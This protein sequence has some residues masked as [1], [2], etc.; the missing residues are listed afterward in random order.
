M[1]LH[2]LLHDMMPPQWLLNY[3]EQELPAEE[4]D[5]HDSLIE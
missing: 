3:E 5:L 2:E 1:N 4:D